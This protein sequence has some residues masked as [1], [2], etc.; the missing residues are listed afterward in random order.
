MSK[1]QM[2]RVF[3]SQRLTAAAEEI[4]GLFERTIAEYE[5]QLCR[6][7]EKNERQQKLLDAV[8]NPQLHLHRAD[9]QETLV[10]EEVPPEQ[11][12][13]SYRL[14]Q[15]QNQDHDQN[16]D[17][18]QD[19]EQNQDQNQNQNQEPPRVKE[20]LWSGEEGEQLQADVR[21]PSVP[22][23][24]EED[25]EKPPPSC[26]YQR[27]ECGATARLKTEAEGE[28]CGG[29]ELARVSDPG[30]PLGAVRD[31]QM[32]HFNTDVAAESWT[33]SGASSHVSLY[34]NVLKDVS[35]FRRHAA[36]KSFGCPECGKTFLHKGNLKS[37][38]MCH[39]GEKP[40]SCPVCGKRFRQNSNLVTH[41][42]TH[43][44]EKP[45]SCSVCH[46]TFSQRGAL[47]QHM[48]IHTGEKPFSCP[49]CG[50]SFTQKGSM[51][52]HMTVHTGEKPF[53]CSV[54]GK[55]FQRPVHVKN[56]RCVPFT[57]ACVGFNQPGMWQ[58]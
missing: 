10:G 33:D 35:E 17:Q 34:L 18:N 26:F 40:F 19:Q 58:S 25:E 1:N 24:S 16:R 8:L 22:V 2:L 7:K 54:C 37:H 30:V 52:E 38:M 45:Y 43:T 14:D 49:I 32:S 55:G 12:E 6:S 27:T 39:T 46:S 48:R 29:P 51:T 44:A 47:G 9:V 3:V 23:K 11:Q 13:W 31:Y 20:E 41:V 5:E 56:H 21:F 50:K 57:D 15:D 36:K 4:F 28:D 53:S 42:R